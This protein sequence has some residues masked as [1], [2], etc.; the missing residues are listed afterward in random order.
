MWTFLNVP[1]FL[2]R[3]L[4]ISVTFGIVRFALT[5]TLWEGPIMFPGLRE[6]GLRISIGFQQPESFH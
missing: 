3:K 5:G 6:F 1:I 4:V 2:N